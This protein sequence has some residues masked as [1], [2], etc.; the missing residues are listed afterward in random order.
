MFLKEPVAC[1]W[2]EDKYSCTCFF[3]LFD[4]CH[5]LPHCSSWCFFSLVLSCYVFIIFYLLLF[6]AEVFSFVCPVLLRRSFACHG[7]V[8]QLW[9][10]CTPWLMCFVSSL[11]MA[12]AAL[13]SIMSRLFIY[14]WL[15]NIT[16]LPHLP[17]E[18]RFHRR[19]TGLKTTA[20]TAGY[21][22]V[23]KG[24]GNRFNRLNRHNRL[25]HLLNRSLTT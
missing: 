14:F 24:P 15:H 2:L 8:V 7:L 19:V 22:A 10:C 21:L 20:F 23:T 17:I 16:L 3:A 6:F 9:C 4:M 13:S 25:Y 1:I 11:Q 5:R 12:Y 18:N